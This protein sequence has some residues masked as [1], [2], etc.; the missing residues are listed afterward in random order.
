MRE[1]DERKAAPARRAGDGFDVV[2]ECAVVDGARS[3]V[4]HAEADP[5]AG[6]NTR[7]LFSST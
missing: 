6:T 3:A 5:E 7:S 2:G 4:E 1:V